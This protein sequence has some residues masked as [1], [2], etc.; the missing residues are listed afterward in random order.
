MKETFDVIGLN[1]TIGCIHKLDN[2]VSLENGPVAKLIIEAGGIPFIKT[3]V[4]VVYINFLSIDY[5][6]WGGFII[7]FILKI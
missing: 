3:N 2:N 6:M 7:L 5:S 4:C 1:S